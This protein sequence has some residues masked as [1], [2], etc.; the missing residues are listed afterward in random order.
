[1]IIL[2]HLPLNKRRECFTFFSNFPP[3]LIRSHFSLFSRAFV[4][5]QQETN[6]G[7]LSKFQLTHMRSMQRTTVL[8]Q[9]MALHNHNV[10]HSRSF[11]E[12]LKGGATYI[13]SIRFY[14][15]LQHSDIACL[16]CRC[17]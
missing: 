13:F 7:L 10:I 12:S 5:L 9:S 17:N 11:I 16:V 2:P 6:Q 4:I 3:F 15:K 8:V 14:V 1:M